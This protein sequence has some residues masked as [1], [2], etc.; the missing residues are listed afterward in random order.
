ME[1]KF[2]CEFCPEFKATNGYTIWDRHVNS[3]KHRELAGIV[4]TKEADGYYHCKECNKLFAFLSELK[5][6]TLRHRNKVKSTE[7]TIV[8]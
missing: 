8:L 1:K 3:K 7:N 4:P 2:K 5:A 6:H